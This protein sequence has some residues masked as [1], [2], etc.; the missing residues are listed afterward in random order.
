MIEGEPLDAQ[1]SPSGK[2]EAKRGREG[3]GRE[4]K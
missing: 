3:V 1:N 2:A 4:E